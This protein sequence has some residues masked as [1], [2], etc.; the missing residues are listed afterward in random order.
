M[1]QYG[2]T[3]DR[4]AARTYADN[5]NFTFVIHRFMWWKKSECYINY[6]NFFDVIFDRWQ[7]PYVWILMLAFSASFAGI[8][9][10]LPT[11]SKNK[12]LGIRTKYTM[13]SDRC[14]KLTHRFAGQLWVVTGILWT[15]INIFGLI[16]NADSVSALCIL[17]VFIMIDILIPCIY[18][19]KNKDI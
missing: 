9:N 1:R 14:W 5:F 12:L 3:M 7:L 10:Y 8:G 17:F 4:S 11:V 18:S 2:F 15:V 16:S 13:Q 6:F 19:H